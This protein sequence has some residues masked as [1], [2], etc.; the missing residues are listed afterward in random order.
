MIVGRSGRTPAKHALVSAVFGREVGVV[1][2]SQKHLGIRRHRWF[3]L[4]AGDAAR[5]E[6]AWT[7][8]CSIGIMADHARQ[9][10]PPVDIETREIDRR[11]FGRLVANLMIELPELGY[12]QIGEAAWTYQDHVTLR[13]INESSLEASAAD[14]RSSD[15]V[16]VFH[17]PN[18]I[19]SWA[20]R[21]TFVNEIVAR[22]PWC[23]RTITTL[24][25]NVG[26]GKRT[27][28]EERAAWYELVAPQC[29]A[30]PPHRDLM[31]ADI[32]GDSSQWAYLICEAEK[33]RGDAEREVRSAF[34]HY[35]YTM[36]M[37]WLRRD[38]AAFRATFDRLFLT[39]EE[40]RASEQPALFAS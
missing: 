9:A 22:G 30:L 27:P 12:R 19:L 21:P 15:A 18:S 5:G 13:A 38:R 23:V 1:A 39:R 17:D 35:G 8:Q 16:L 33:W 11:I 28:P 29:R 37:A 7:R 14:V 3:D 40:L 2:K 25:C 32:D 4:N 20:M 34:G 10:R 36:N 24:G 6:E 26:G 31:I